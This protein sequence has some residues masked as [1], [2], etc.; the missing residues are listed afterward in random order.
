MERVRCVA[1]PVLATTGHEVRAALS[2]AG[3]AFRLTQRMAIDQVDALRRAAGTVA[4]VLG[5]QGLLTAQA[6]TPVST[7]A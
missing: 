6:Q 5:D 7:E 2:L 3:P 1:V 4:R